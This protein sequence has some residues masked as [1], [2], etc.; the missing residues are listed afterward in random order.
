MADL[1]KPIGDFFRLTNAENDEGLSVL[2]SED[3]TVID[4]GERKEVRGHDEIARWIEKSISGLHLQTDVRG[5]AEQDGV[6]I[7]DTVLTGNFKAS[8]AR[9]EYF[10]SLTGEKI[11]KLRVEFRGSLK[12]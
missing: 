4:A 11:S 3:A 10:I 7:V 12:Q 1:P 9:F 6:W 2:F 8:P 5:W